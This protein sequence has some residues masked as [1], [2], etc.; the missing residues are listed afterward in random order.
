MK[1]RS[2]KKREMAAKIVENI[3]EAYQWR[4]QMWQISEARKK[5]NSGVMAK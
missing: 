2:K 4:R 3:N 1:Q 5:E